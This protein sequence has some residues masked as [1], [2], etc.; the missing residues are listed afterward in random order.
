MQPVYDW[1]MGRRLVFDD[2]WLCNP[3]VHQGRISSRYLRMGLM[4]D[5]GFMGYWEGHAL[6]ETRTS[7]FPCSLCPSHPS[8]RLRYPMRA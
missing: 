5:W 6:I 1:A 2:L 4:G 7:E 3:Q 8:L